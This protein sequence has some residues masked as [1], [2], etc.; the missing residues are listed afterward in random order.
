MG[1]R[2]LCKAE[3]IGSIPICSTTPKTM[4][5]PC[6][7]CRLREI[8]YVIQGGICEVCWIDWWCG[9]VFNKDMD[10][11]ERAAYRR[12]VKRTVKEVTKE[13]R[14]E[15]RRERNMGL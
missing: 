3:V 5:N 6:T 11:R 14:R 2:G 1:E 12:E 9:G 15:D 13:R 7:K 10:A 8:E 4:E